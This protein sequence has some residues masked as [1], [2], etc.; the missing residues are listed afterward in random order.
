MI[1]VSKKLFNIALSVKLVEIG[2]N[3]GGWNGQILHQLE[4]IQ[5]N[6]NSPKK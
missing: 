6:K 3:L 1:N 4:Q 5:T 2:N